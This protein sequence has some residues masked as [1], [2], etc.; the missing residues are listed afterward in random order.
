MSN[1]PPIADSL[2]HHSRRMGRRDRH[3]AHRAATPL[4]LLFDLTFSVTLALVEFVAPILAERKD[5]GTSWHAHHIAERH[6]LF[7][8]IVN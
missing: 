6:G 7:A 4:E 5:G 2:H 8:I 3:E 1:T